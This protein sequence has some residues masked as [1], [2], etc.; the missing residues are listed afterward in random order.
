MKLF[1]PAT[2]NLSFA[3]SL[4][5]NISCMNPGNNE[6]HS[7]KSLIKDTLKRPPFVSGQAKLLRFGS[8]QE[9]RMVWA[10]YIGP[11]K[12]N[13]KVFDHICMIKY[14]YTD[15][16]RIDTVFY[17]NLEIRNGK[18]N[19]D[20]REY[21]IENDQIDEGTVSIT[22]G[23]DTV[24]LFSVLKTDKFDEEY[25]GIKF[26]HM[27]SVRE[28][29]KGSIIATGLVE[30][31]LKQE[32]G[33]QYLLTLR[34]GAKIPYQLCAG[35]KGALEDISFM[36]RED[37]RIYLIERSCYLELVNREDAVLLKKED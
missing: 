12:K 7:G 29:G 10:E 16:V 26:T 35:C 9:P 14:Y 11:L 34:N 18:I 28:V 31:N 6:E 20:W 15:P 36:N 5:F 22:N 30:Y 23:K 37:G 1:G 2:I 25:N 17:E 8:A 33:N 19:P 24:D 13:D 21:K 4:F 27:P 3:V 32:N